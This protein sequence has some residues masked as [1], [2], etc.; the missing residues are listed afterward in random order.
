MIALFAASF[1]FLAAP[2]NASVDWKEDLPGA[3]QAAKSK[4]ELVLVDFSATWCYSCHYMDQHVLGE[5][6][7]QPLASKLELVRL[8]VDST[9]GTKFRREYQALGLPNYV[10]LDGDGREVGRIVGE[11]KKEDFF[12]QLHEIVAK[13]APLSKLESAALAGGPK[14]VPAA[15]AVLRSYSQKDAAQE[16]LTFFGRLPKPLQ[17]EIEADAKGRAELLRLKLFVAFK[18]KDAGVC[19]RLGSALLA[20]R[21][22]CDLMY[23]ALYLQHCFD[24]LPKDK[25]AK[26][27]APERKAI[28]ALV[29]RGVLVAPAQRC[30][31]LQ[32]G[33]KVA[34]RF[35]RAVGERKKASEILS[36][37]TREMREELGD[38]L[39]RDRN[40]AYNLLEFL[41]LAEDKAGLR[42]LYPRLVAA[43]PKDYVYPLLY[44]R[45]LIE[46]GEPAKALEA[47]ESAKKTAFGA[48][49]LRVA[50]AR[51]K[52]LAKLGRKADALA[53]LD[54]ALKD[55]AAFPKESAALQKTRDELK[56]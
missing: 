14:A 19:E 31:D 7:M 18:A 30:A 27:I 6:E 10:V 23:D 49:V 28:E 34:V 4:G 45:F 17:R 24:D 5:P 44:G 50:N 46:E 32:T 1:Y 13:S 51:A 25:Q 39:S 2:A 29:A 36:R 16:G 53:E 41:E 47:L 22:D 20:G 55:G 8:D 3:L 11:Q 33:A 56:G 12:K 43:Y 40:K 48:G 54:A 37:L 42:E 21:S 15:V 52:A 26:A 38:D 9:E 35:Y